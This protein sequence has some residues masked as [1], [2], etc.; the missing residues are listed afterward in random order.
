MLGLGWQ[1]RRRK[2]IGGWAAA[3]AAVV[4]AGDPPVAGSS[5]LSGAEVQLDCLPL[6]L[7]ADFLTSQA[8]LQAAV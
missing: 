2:A 7:P 1:S 5:R 8:D 6:S 3:A 4:E